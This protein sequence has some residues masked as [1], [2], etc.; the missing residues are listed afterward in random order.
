LAQIGKYSAIFAVIMPNANAPIL[1]EPGRSSE[2]A[3]S[4]GEVDSNDRAFEV[5]YLN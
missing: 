2:L 4:T 3:A 5:Y 1:R